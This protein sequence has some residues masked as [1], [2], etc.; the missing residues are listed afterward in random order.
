MASLTGTQINNTY[1]GLLKFTDNLGVTGTPK[2]ITDGLGSGLPVSF[3]SNQT[4]FTDTVDFSAAT[5]TGLPGGSAGLVS[6]AGADSMKSDDSLTTTGTIALFPSEIILGNGA[7]SI[8]GTANNDYTDWG[9]IAV[10]RDAQITKTTD[11]SFAPSR[12]GIAIGYDTEAV[13]GNSIG[14]ST[15][16]GDRARATGAHGLA[17]GY[18]SLQN[19]EGAVAI[20][21]RSTQA[22][23]NYTVALGDSAKALGY[24]AVAIGHATYA[25]GGGFQSG[26]TAI[27]NWAE[28]FAPK[29][30]YIG[31]NGATQVTGG[32]AIGNSIDI[33]GTG[34][35]VIVIGNNNN[36]PGGENNQDLIAVGSGLSISGGNYNTIMMGLI[37]SATNANDSIILGRQ[38]ASTAAYSAALGP[39]TTV[40]A[41]GGTAVGYQ[42]TNNR[43]NFVTVNELEIS[44]VGGGIIMPSPD[45][46]LYKLTIANG[47]TVSVA[48]V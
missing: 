42:V 9:G 7:R 44:V 41:F 10:G 1:P 19:A 36:V 47:G 11:Y 23:A 32:I 13:I 14:S 38:A 8:Q 37:A 30:V 4:I 2:E 46:T 12:G 18:N 25:S 45:G 43:S 5:V 3:S 48:A 15:A 34:G 16:I 6:G 40:N 29:A 33:A 24:D 22:T 26:S 39:Q 20:G 31:T 17:I 35:N 27:G 21:S 28:C